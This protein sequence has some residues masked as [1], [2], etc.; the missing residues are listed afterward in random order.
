MEPTTELTEGGRA[1]PARTA[2]TTSTASAGSFLGLLVLLHLIKPEVDPSWQMI[3]D[4]GVGGFGWVMSVAFLSLAAS[5]VAAAVALRPHLRSW[6]SRIGA[7]FLLIAA[8]GLIIGG[9][10]PVDPVGEE[11]TFQGEMHGVGF[12]LG[13]PGFLVA[14]TLI[15]GGLA[16][17]PGWARARRAVLWAT[18]LVWLSV[19]GFAVAMAV[20]FDG[21]L[22]PEQY[23]PD[24]PIGWPNRLLILTYAVWLLTVARQ[25]RHLAASVDR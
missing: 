6:P 4:Y 12:M 21:S 20:L 22:G 23:G 25:A 18:S 11:I 13:V 9:V 7:V 19:V 2:A 10:F 3:S 15:S 14:A 8:L 24:T 1:T 16:R 5:C 17:D